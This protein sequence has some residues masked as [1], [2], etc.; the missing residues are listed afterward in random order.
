MPPGFDP[1]NTYYDRLSITFNDGNPPV[2]VTVPRNGQPG[3]E[4]TGPTDY[5]LRVVGKELSVTGV[6]QDDDYVRGSWDVGPDGKKDLKLRLN[7]LSTY[8]ITYAALYGPANQTFP[9]GVTPQ[10]WFFG[11]AP[12]V[13]T[14]N[15]WRME[16][17]QDRTSAGVIS[18][19][20]A[21]VAPGANLAGQ[22]L[23][24]IVQYPNG[25][26]DSFPRGATTFTAST[27][28]PSAVFVA[29]VAPYTIAA[30]PGTV[31]WD[32]Q[33]ASAGPHNRAGDV[34]LNVDGLP[35]S[36]G[37]ISNLVLSDQYGQL[38][39]RNIFGIDV[40]GP[41]FS[42]A[43]GSSHADVY[44]P[45]MRDETGTQLTLR[46]TLGGTTYFKQF[47]GG[48][49]DPAL[50]FPNTMSPAPVLEVTPD[51]NLQDR[52]DNT[53]AGVIWMQPSASGGLVYQLYQ[54]LRISRPVTLIANRGVELRFNLN[55]GWATANGAILVDASHV[56]LN[57][58]KI[59]FSGTMADWTFQED[60]RAVVQM[61]GG[62]AG[63]TSQFERESEIDL[64]L[65]GLD[66]QVPGIGPNQP[67]P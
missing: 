15:H 47:A 49:Y 62:S 42:H 54:H 11:E 27:T 46:F 5:Y 3:F 26:Q 22:A 36:G 9:D 34:H 30:F 40:P 19:A 64:A 18:T 45:P 66:I 8:G 56:A 57:G 29:N 17:F 50:R 24:L 55:S 63:G 59:T 31:S 48:S 65:T 13:D 53:T 25:K 44:F 51:V 7:N 14:N 41:T 67:V 21:Y 6:T 61:V 39:P 23:K 37:T 52:I 33:L 2:E 38:W 1:I 60:K 43:A 28:D 35:T 58:L 4:L 16:L 12:A 10:Q 20:D 32:R